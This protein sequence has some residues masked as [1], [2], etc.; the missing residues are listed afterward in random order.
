VLQVNTIDLQNSKVLIQPEQAEATKG[1]S[2]VI[3]ENALSL[4]MRKF[5][6]EKWW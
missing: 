6:L 4:L 2:V 5:C 1:K 3:G